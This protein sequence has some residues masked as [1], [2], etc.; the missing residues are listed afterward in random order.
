MM[1]EEAMPMMVERRFK[2]QFSRK[3]LGLW[4]E[5]QARTVGFAEGWWTK[6]RH[7]IEVLLES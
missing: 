5:G 4:K 2:T 1:A 7:E 3:R 6:C